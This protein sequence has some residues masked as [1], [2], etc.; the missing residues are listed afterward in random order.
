MADVTAA[1]TGGSARRRALLFRVH[2]WAGVIA[3]AGVLMWALSGVFH[4]VM[5]R[6]QPR[7]VTFAP[8]VQ[9]LQPDQVLPLSEVLRKNGIDAIDWF[10]LVNW[11]AGQH[12]QLALPGR[13]ELVYLDAASG[14]PLA[15][16]DRSYAAYLARHYLGDADSGILE[17]RAVSGFGPEYSYIN[18]LLPAYRVS[19]DREDAMRVYVD[20]A[21]SRLGTLVDRNKAWF[22]AY[23]QALHSWAFLESW[24]WLRIMLMLILL[25]AAFL[26]AVLGVWMFAARAGFGSRR[27]GLRRWHRFSAIGVAVATGT[28]TFSGAYHLLADASREP[29]EVRHRDTGFRAADFGG[30]SGG[31]PAAASGMQAVRGVTPARIDGQVYYR[32]EPVPARF[33]HNAHDHS[34]TDART[35]T[36]ATQVLFVNAADG[37]RLD[38]GELQYARSL[39]GRFSGLPSGQIAAVSE[40]TRF[41]GEYG[42]VFKRLPV[43][44]VAYSAPGNPRYYVEPRTGAL[45]AR[46]DD[47]DAREGWTFAYLHKFEWLAPLGPLFRDGIAMLFALGNALVAALGLA[48]FLRR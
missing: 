36:H 5:T 43:M 23:F 1:T 34:R 2:R 33:A 14:L 42:F 32:L 26:T 8:P 30:G 11:P 28:F 19:F 10:R 25:G 27:G 40:V 21:S 18:R 29:P 45:A 48:L 16:G 6:L 31:L 17:I 9:V 38:D 39:A 20:T 4:P 37:K 24:P 13:A 47:G 3:C 41:A 12:Y 35:A 15:G 44:R 7:A 46:I 22:S